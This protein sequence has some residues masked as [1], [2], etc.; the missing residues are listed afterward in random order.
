[1]TTLTFHQRCHLSSF[2]QNVTTL[3]LLLLVSFIQAMMRLAGLWKGCDY[4]VSIAIVVT[5]LSFIQAVTNFFH[6]GCDYSKF[7]LQRACLLLVSII[8]VLVSL[9]SALTTLSF[10]YKTINI[11]WYM[12]HRDIIKKKE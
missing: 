9:R 3:C 12:S 11:F 7:P 2:K 5:T 10:I 6:A 4:S 8:K 1:M